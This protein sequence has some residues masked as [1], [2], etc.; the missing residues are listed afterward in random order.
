[1]SNFTTIINNPNNRAKETNVEKVGRAMEKMAGQKTEILAQSNGTIPTVDMN[2]LK[3]LPNGSAGRKA[4]IDICEALAIAPVVDG[5]KGD[6]IGQNDCPGV[7]A[8]A[9]SVKFVFEDTQSM[10][11]VIPDTG[12]LKYGLEHAPMEESTSYEG[13]VRLQ[14]EKALAEVIDEDIENIVTDGNQ[15]TQLRAKI[16]QRINENNPPLNPEITF[17]QQLGAYSVRQCD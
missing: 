13:V 7:T 4:A 14:I 1:M 8:S 17:F 3:N 2:D 5:E 15:R 11:V 12:V 6:V 16:Q 9:L 10:I